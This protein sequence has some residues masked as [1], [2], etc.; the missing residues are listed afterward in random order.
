MPI[1][2]AEI[3]GFIK[4]ITPM[5]I[6]TMAKTVVNTGAKLNSGFMTDAYNITNPI[7]VN[8]HAPKGTWLATPL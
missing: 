1:I 3:T 8:Y 4:N 5:H 6:N 2:P 7:I